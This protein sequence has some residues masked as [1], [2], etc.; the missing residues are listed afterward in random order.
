MLL[1]D[2]LGVEVVERSIDRTEV[3]LAEEIF[4]CGT[5]VQIAA[6]NKVDHR[7]V[8]T[9]K[10]GPITGKLRTLYFDVVKGRVPKYREMCLPVY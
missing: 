3:Y 5:G 10:M 4:F 1:R 9:G 2:E 6:I 7:P 8:G